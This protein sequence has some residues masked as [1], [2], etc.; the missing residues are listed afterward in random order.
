VTT[1]INV[2]VGNPRAD[3]RTLL[4]AAGL[5]RRLSS[6]Q[7]VAIGDVVDLAS[8]SAGIFAWPNPELDELVQRVGTSK[9]LIVAS[10]VYKGAYTGLLKAFFDRFDSDGLAGV[11]AIPV[12][13]VGSPAHSLAAE[14]SLR[15][16]L[17]ELGASVPTQSLVFSTS[18]FANVEQIL[19]EWTQANIQPHG[20]VLGPRLRN[21]PSS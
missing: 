8:H 16:L 11:T 10:P 15:P 7:D 19:D 6:A 5:A 3:S 13:T 20:A 9:I 14:M 1:N 18:Q 4:V 21:E 12:M 2:V 17:V